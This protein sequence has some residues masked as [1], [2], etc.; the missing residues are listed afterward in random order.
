LI[1]EVFEDRTVNEAAGTLT[2]S[3][4]RQSMGFTPTYSGHSPFTVELPFHE[5]QTLTAKAAKELK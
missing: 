3:N 1:F 4:Q 2:H 5:P